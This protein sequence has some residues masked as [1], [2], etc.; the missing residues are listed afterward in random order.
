MASLSVWSI[1]G[2]LSL[3]QTVV[4]VSVGPSRFPRHYHAGLMQRCPRAQTSQALI[5]FFLDA[6]LVH[7]DVLNLLT[8]ICAAGDGIFEGFAVTW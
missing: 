5:F 1:Y 7:R 3:S 4:S 8:M 2:Y 6:Y